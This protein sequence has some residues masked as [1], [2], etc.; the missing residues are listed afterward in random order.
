MATFI[1]LLCCMDKFDPQLVT[2][3]L[4][5][6]HG[7]FRLIEKELQKFVIPVKTVYT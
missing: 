3:V 4:S 6:F 7:V 5:E 1:Y 2:F